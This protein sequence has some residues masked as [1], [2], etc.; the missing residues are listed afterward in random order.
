LIADAPLEHLIDDE[1]RTWTIRRLPTTFAPPP[2]PP[3]PGSGS[4]VFDAGATDHLNSEP[5]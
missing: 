5:G 4:V 1:G 2:A 3:A